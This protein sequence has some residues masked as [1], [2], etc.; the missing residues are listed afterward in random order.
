MIQASGGRKR[1]QAEDSFGKSFCRTFW[2]RVDG[3]NET[4][5]HVGESVVRGC[6]F[7]VALIAAGSC[8]MS[9]AEPLSSH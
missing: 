7:V 1:R 9:A 2:C 3:N 4:L 5:V 8:D 6:R